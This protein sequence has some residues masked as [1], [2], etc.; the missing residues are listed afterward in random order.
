MARTKPIMIYCYK[1]GQLYKLSLVYQSGFKTLEEAL[2][3]I[4]IN[5]AK[6]RFKNLQLVFVEYKDPYK[7]EIIHILKT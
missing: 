2:A 6:G 1:L 4:E 7:S 3:F 5:L